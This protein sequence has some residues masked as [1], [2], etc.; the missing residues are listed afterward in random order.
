[1]THQQTVLVTGASSGFGRLIAEA[2]AR[3]GDTVFATMRDPLRR[4]AAAAAEL[5]DLARKDS[6]DIRVADLDVAD[7]ASVEKTVPSILDEAGHLDVLVNNAG[8]MDMGL[9]ET[10]T[11][12][13]AR[14]ILDTNYFG[15]L[16]TT[17]AV[18]PA[19]RRRGSGLLVHITSGLGRLVIPF[20]AHYN[21]S[22]FAVEAFSETLRYELAPLGVDSVT[23]EPGAYPTPILGKGA[24]GEDAERLE[25]YEPSLAVLETMGAN[26][27]TFLTSDEAPDPREVAEAV[28][29]LI[30]TPFGSRPARTAVG[31]DVRSLADF[32]QTAAR[33][34]AAW[35]DQLG[36]R[37]ALQP[38][39]AAI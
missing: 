6:L 35:L 29:R 9:T 37:E 28:S 17:R 30:E 13:Q 15:V 21:A 3:K 7:D 22:K 19:M 39:P 36:L 33:A 26:F 23:L 38:A 8:I 14:R 12:G 20:A 31:E 4:N 1:M 32:N 10:Y 18:L 34:Q 2:R 16:R 11:V 25:G 24:P 5:R 27:Q